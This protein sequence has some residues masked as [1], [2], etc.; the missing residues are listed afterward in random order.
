MGS[1]A[2]SCVRCG[3]VEAAE[4]FSGLRSAFATQARGANTVAG[5]DGAFASAEA[6]GGGG[7]RVNAVS[8][9]KEGQAEVADAGAGLDGVPRGGVQ[10]GVT[11]DV[12][13]GAGAVAGL[14]DASAG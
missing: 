11:C 8:G 10:S 2:Q 6:S 9:A 13:G 3:A 5:S 4:A 1:E 12:V 7:S 14:R